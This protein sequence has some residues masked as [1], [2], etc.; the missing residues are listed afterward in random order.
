MTEVSLSYTKFSEKLQSAPDEIDKFN[1]TQIS[2]LHN[3]TQTLRSNM[4]RS[5]INDEMS[6][7]IPDDRFR[8]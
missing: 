4:N 6:D 7:F 5:E 1:P 3:G 2:I 8:L